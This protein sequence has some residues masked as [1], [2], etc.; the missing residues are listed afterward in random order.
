[1][2]IDYAGV[3]ARLECD[4]ELLFEILEAFRYDAPSQLEQLRSSLEADDAK[5]AEL[6][7]HTLKGMS[8]NIGAERF[9]SMVEEIEKS[10]R[11][12]DLVAARK[13]SPSLAEGLERLLAEIATLPGSSSKGSLYI[14]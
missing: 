4:D 12:G 11:T 2:E 14:D 1:M 8:G 5:G 13:L 9:R 10:V 7:A 3:K 6:Y